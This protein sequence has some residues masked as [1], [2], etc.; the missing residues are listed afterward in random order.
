MPKSGIP[1][2]KKSGYFPTSASLA[3]SKNGCTP[4]CRAKQQKNVQMTQKPAFDLSN[5]Y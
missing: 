1:H 2:E 5:Q 3:R 4:V